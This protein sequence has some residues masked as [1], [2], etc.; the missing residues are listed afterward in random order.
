VFAA[1]SGL[2]IARA[3]DPATAQQIV[4]I[5]SGIAI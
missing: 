5:I 1:L 2:A 3:F 4:Q